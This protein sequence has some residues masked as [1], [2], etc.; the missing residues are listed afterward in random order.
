MRGGGAAILGILLLSAVAGAGAQTIAAADLQRLQE[1]VAAI[2]QDIAAMRAR[3][4]ATA[5]ALQAEL[6][7]LQDEVTYL[8]VK[9]RKEPD[10]P[11]VE[12]TDLRDRLEDLKA[13]ARGDE[14]SAGAYARPGAAPA[15]KPGSSSAAIP[16]G[17]ELDVRLQTP[18][19]SGTAQVED[20]FEATTLVDLRRDGRVLIPAGSVARGVVTAVKSAGR[21]D[22]KGSLSL[23]FERLTVDGTTY[24]IRGTLVQAA[25]S[26]GVKAEAGKIG[27]GAA[28]GGVLGGILGGWRGSL[29]GIL[30]GGG[31][32][33]IASEGRQVDLKPGTVLRMRF[34][35]PLVLK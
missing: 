22:R 16:V 18:L 15:P 9:L 20:R 4:A 35:E 26:E 14:G 6:S 3:D 11:L 30:L 25:E 19:N 1:T 13:R 34:D 17:T 27:A 10:V 5:R 24:Q 29:A 8:K 12:Y 7:D 23:A 32:T 2:G 28:V 21:I 33:M 31:G